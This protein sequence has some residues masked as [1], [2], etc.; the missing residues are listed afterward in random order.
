MIVEGEVATLEDL[1]KVNTLLAPYERKG[2]VHVFRYDDNGTPYNADPSDPDQR[3]NLTETLVYSA[4]ERGALAP[5]W[6][7]RT[8]RLQQDA[9]DPNAGLTEEERLALEANAVVVNPTAPVGG[10]DRKPT[11]T[12]RMIA[13]VATGRMP[14]FGDNPD[15]PDMT[16]L[17]IERYM[18]WGL[19]RE[20]LQSGKP[21]IGI[22]QTGS[23]LSPCNRHHLVLADRLRDAA[24]EVYGQKR[25]EVVRETAEVVAKRLT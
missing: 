25:Q 16:A 23:D 15:D 22:A 7:V 3:R 11:P 4:L 20:E 17:Y 19:T 18:N 1:R 2:G 21:I 24:A 12:G 10:G 6:E 14:G 5:M 13:S 9:G 8:A